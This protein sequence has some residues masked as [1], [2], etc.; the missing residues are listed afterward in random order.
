MAQALS[1]KVQQGLAIMSQEEK[2]EIWNQAGAMIAA[3]LFP[4]KF[5]R[6][7]EAFAAALYGRELGLSP[8]R[9]WKVIHIIEGMPCLEAH[10]Q[11]TFAKQANPG[12]IWGV[13]EH[14]DEICVI[15]HGLK[16]GKLYRTSFSYEE[17]KLMGKTGP[18]ASGKPSNWM[19]HRRDMLYAR[20]AT[21]AVKWYYP[22]S[23]GGLV[24]SL[25]EMREVME[26]AAPIRDTGAPRAEK[27]SVEVIEAA[28][29]TEEAAITE[30]V[31]EDPEALETLKGQLAL[32]ADKNAVD[33]TYGKWRSANAG[34][35]HTL[36]EG[37][38][39]V[40]AKLHA[41]AHPQETQA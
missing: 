15:E 40:S 36:L 22:E 10:Q 4:S 18:S 19:K 38:D 3:G 35:P 13:V 12:L 6:K 33:L 7:E 16:D 30:T 23:Q 1:T 17:A 39:L 11:V 20:A 41:I 21:R 9:A 8:Q 32:S 37:Y 24:H 27:V 28:T 25:E 14:T 26:E 31:V 5:K 34:K 29:A 2:T